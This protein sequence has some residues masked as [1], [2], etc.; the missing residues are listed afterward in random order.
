MFRK[1]STHLQLLSSAS[2][3]SLKNIVNY[4]SF[5]TNKAVKNMS[6]RSYDLVI[7][8]ATGFTGQYVVEEVARVKELEE[9]FGMREKP[10]KWAIAGRNKEKLLKTLS[11]AEKEAGKI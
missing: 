2:S 3:N 5:S 11:T 1:I 9:K 4:N 8:G 7:Y 6:N 10:V